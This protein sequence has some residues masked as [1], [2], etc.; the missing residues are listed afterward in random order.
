MQTTMTSSGANSNGVD[1]LETLSVCT[2]VTTT[3]TDQEVKQIISSPPLALAAVCVTVE[4]KNDTLPLVT[5]GVMEEV[6]C[7]S[8]RLPSLFETRTT[9][10]KGSFNNVRIRLCYVCAHTKKQNKTNKSHHGCQDQTLHV[11]RV[12]NVHVCVGLNY[13]YAPKKTKKIPHTEN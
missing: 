4:E 5:G 13:M 9:C 1:T 12:R 2:W 10:F 8:D 6:T 7:K 11:V 3:Q